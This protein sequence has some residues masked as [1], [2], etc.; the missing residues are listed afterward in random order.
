MS[1]MVLNAEQVRTWSQQAVSMM[2]QKQVMPLSRCAACICPNP[3]TQPA[4]L[5]TV[6]F[7]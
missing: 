2:L 5:D 3:S 7:W 1:D 6:A 4:H